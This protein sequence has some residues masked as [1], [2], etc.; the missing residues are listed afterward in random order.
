MLSQR[1]RQ[2]SG[3][4][5]RDGEVRSFDENSGSVGLARRPKNTNAARCGLHINYFFRDILVTKFRGFY[6]MLQNNTFTQTVG[7]DRS[8]IH[9]IRAGVPRS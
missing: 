8:G 5:D 9:V 1:C 6:S 2:I 3:L 7:I 4:C